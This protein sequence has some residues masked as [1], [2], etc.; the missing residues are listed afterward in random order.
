MDLT[1]EDFS[2]TVFSV[3]FL[4][5]SACLILA[6]QMDLLTKEEREA[7]IIEYDHLHYEIWQRGQS[8]W[9]VNS[10]LITGS[11]LAA[12]QVYNES[13]PFPAISLLLIAVSCVTQISTEWVN[14]ISYRR[15]KEIGKRLG[16]VGPEKMYKSYL[17]EKWWYP[18][19]RNGSYFLFLILASIYLFLIFHS[20]FILIIAVVVGLLTILGREAYSYMKRDILRSIENE[21]HMRERREKN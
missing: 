16:I 2:R 9:V 12:F 4:V 13:F 14:I 11:L 10:I 7:L 8:I 6:F 3:V 1:I 15:M 20:I 18:I 19:R 5:M 21:K 17:E